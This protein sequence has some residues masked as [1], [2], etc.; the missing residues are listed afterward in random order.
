MIMTSLY[1]WL[2]E[3]L[4]SFYWLSP[5]PLYPAAMAGSIYSSELAQTVLATADSLQG[6]EDTLDRISLHSSRDSSQ[7]RRRRRSSQ[8][9]TNGDSAI[10]SLH[11]STDEESSLRI[12]RKA[13]THSDWDW[14]YHTDST[15]KVHKRKLRPVELSRREGSM[16][17]LS[18]S[19]DSSNSRGS[20]VLDTHLSQDDIVQIAGLS[21][22]LKR[23]QSTIVKSKE[24]PIEHAQIV[25][26]PSDNDDSDGSNSTVM[27]DEPPSNKHITIDPK[28][29]YREDPNERVI[30]KRSTSFLQ[31]LKLGRVTSFKIERKKSVPVRRSMSDRVMYQIKRGLIEYK[32]G[33]NFISRP[34]HMRRIG[35]MI[36]KQAG[37]FHIVQLHRPP[38]G[39]YGIYITQSILRRGIFVARFDDD[40]TAK[41]YTGLLAPG[42]EI[43]KV[44]TV[45]VKEKSVDY[46]YN[47]MSQLN[48]VVFTIVPVNSRPDW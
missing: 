31:R 18:S 19:T 24:I 25:Y 5:S 6:L 46:V 34:S 1:Y 42:D 41:F 20:K 35:R 23:R 43:I 14:L 48:S 39:R 21:S 15:P 16:L 33:M 12:K 13:H 27:A 22:Q 47:I 37:K 30:P 3:P 9:S 36:D 28:V 45:R 40:G 29:S 38:T 7:R 8:T 17:S 2:H 10:G 4:L 44:N 32:Q 11:T 26:I